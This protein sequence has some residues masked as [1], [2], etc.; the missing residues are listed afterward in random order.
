[1]N[2]G[3]VSGFGVA[4]IVWH[5]DDHK[6]YASIIAPHPHQLVA[7]RHWCPALAIAVRI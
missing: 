6:L 3:Q 5:G 4:T 1:M 7:D 2:N